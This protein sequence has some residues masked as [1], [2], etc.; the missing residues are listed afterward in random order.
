MNLQS[1][2]IVGQSTQSEQSAIGDQSMLMFQDEN[3]HR[4]HLA[5]GSIGHPCST[6]Q[7]L[8][9]YLSLMKPGPSSITLLDQ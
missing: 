6:I 1:G 8:V 2:S 9:W 3:I 7:A 4:I 5:M